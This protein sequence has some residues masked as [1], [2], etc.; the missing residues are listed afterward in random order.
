MDLHP[1]VSLYSK[2]Q[3]GHGSLLLKAT[4]KLFRIIP[5]MATLYTA[6]RF[7]T[8]GPAFTQAVD[9]WL[10]SECFFYGL[11]YLPKS[12]SLQKVQLSVR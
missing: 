3:F 8:Q 2:V 1:T 12:K 4:L 5:V 11:F 9:Y 7:A 6:Y 10:I